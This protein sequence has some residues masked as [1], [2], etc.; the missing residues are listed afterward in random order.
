MPFSVE[1]D[2]EYKISVL[3]RQRLVGDFLKVHSNSNK[4]YKASYELVSEV[5]ELRSKF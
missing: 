3:Y 2:H 5:H 4:E 1:S